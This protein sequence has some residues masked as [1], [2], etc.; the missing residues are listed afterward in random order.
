[1]SALGAGEL[2]IARIC[3]IRARARLRR[4]QI[5]RIKGATV[6][7]DLVI[8]PRGNT[9]NLDIPVEY[10]QSD[11]ERNSEPHEIII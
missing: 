7:N 8:H 5:T 10:H 2:F 11:S 3:I 1:M 4:V 6:S 9:S